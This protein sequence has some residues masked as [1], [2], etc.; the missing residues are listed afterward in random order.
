M[1]L[2]LLNKMEINKPLTV[3]E[4]KILDD[5]SKYGMEVNKPLTAEEA[6]ILDDL[7]KQ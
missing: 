4:A 7:S 2:E 1:N 6:K 3:K 5:L